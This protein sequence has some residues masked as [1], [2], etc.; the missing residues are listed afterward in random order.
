MSQ[1]KKPKWPIALIIR[2]DK[3]GWWLT[4]IILATWEIEIRRILVQ[5]QSGQKVH[6]NPSQPIKAGH[7]RIPIIPTRRKH[8]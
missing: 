1:R 2:N 4:S 6:E 5:T 3:Q 7:G 8:K